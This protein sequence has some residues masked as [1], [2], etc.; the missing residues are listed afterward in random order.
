MATQYIYTHK[1][2]ECSSANTPDRMTLKIQ[3]KT[4]RKRNKSS[5][6]RKG[7]YKWEWGKQYSVTLTASVEAFK[8]QRTSNQICCAVQVKFDNNCI[9]NF[10]VLKC[11][12][13]KLQPRLLPRNKMY[14]FL[15]VVNSFDLVHSNRILSSTKFLCWTLLRSSTYKCIN[16]KQL[17][18]FS[19]TSR[20]SKPT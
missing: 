3:T 6:C 16:Q 8:S 7:I 2:L 9:A 4:V 13:Q 14:Y 19:T 11:I 20:G 12:P 1:N 15:T 18:S 10:W 17:F 5:S